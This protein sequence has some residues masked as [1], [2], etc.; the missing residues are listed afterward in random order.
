MTAATRNRSDSIGQDTEDN[1]WWRENEVR[2]T[3]ESVARCEGRSEELL[4]IGLKGLARHGPVEHERSDEAGAAQ[5]GYEGGGAPMATR[6]CIHQ[7]FA[8]RSPTKFVLAPVSS[9]NT[10]RSGS[11]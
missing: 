6:C 4:D 5:S 2:R 11:M 10:K 1:G 7:A 9:R 8:A 3:S